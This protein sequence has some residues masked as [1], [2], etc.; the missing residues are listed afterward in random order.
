MGDPNDCLN[1][2]GDGKGGEDTADTSNSNGGDDSG[3]H[4]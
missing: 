3:V 2:G 1:R 4:H